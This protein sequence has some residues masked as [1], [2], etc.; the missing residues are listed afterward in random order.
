[1]GKLDYEYKR[2]KSLEMRK[3]ESERIRTK[4]EGRIPVICEKDSKSDLPMIDKTKYLVP[5]DLNMG[6]FLWVIR[7]RLKMDAQRSLFLFVNNSL[8]NSGEPMSKIYE[9]SKDDDGFLYFQYS[10]EH[11]YG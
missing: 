4:Y 2:T 11:T 1:M 7:K 5:E 10:G 9:E 6:Q 8:P 3:Q